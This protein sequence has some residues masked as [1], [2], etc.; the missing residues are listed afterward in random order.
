MNQIRILIDKFLTVLVSLERWC[1]FLIGF[2]ADPH[3]IVGHSRFNLGGD[4]PE[5]V[6]ISSVYTQISPAADRGLLSNAFHNT[7]SE[8]R[9]LMFKLLHNKLLLY[10]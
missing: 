9:V 4:D 7:K 6:D 10:D 2:Y 8:V 3:Y 5:W 1:R